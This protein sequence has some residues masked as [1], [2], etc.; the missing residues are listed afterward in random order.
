MNARTQSANQV[1]LRCGAQPTSHQTVLMERA[2]AKDWL[3]GATGMVLALMVAVAIFWWLVSDPA[4]GG[5]AGPRSP[6]VGA[7]RPPGRQPPADFRG[8]EVW[9]ADLA[10][11]ADT[12]VTAGSMLRDVRAVGQD[13]VTNPDG[14]IAARVTVDATVPFKVIADE[15]GNGTTIRA[16]DDGQ[17]MVVRT[18]EVLGRE[19]SVAATGTVEV[20]AGRL[21]VEPRSIDFGGPDFL[22]DD[23]AAVVRGLVTIEHDIEGLPEGLVLQH[24]TVKDDGFR[25]SLWGEDVKLTP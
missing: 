9:F 23:I 16:G 14:L 19:M 11:D 4:G 5:E 24:V 6:T 10:L 18:V 15:L 22:S 13:V 21:V 17:A 12:L 3:I 1:G 25:A 7:E 20:E 8:D 2:R